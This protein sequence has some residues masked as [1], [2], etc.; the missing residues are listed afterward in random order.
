MQAFRLA[1]AAGDKALCGRI[2]AGM[3][4]QANFLGH[5]QRAADLARAAYKGANGYATP[6]AMALFH[7]MEAR[8]LASMGKDADTS[9]ALLTAERW[10]AQ[11]D[12]GNDPEWIHYFDEAELHAEFAHSFRDLGK[13]DLAHYHAEASVREAGDVYVRSVSFVNTVLATA[14][15]QNGD[16]EQAL[17]IAKSVVETA[18]QLKS[19]RV[20]SY[21]DEFRARLASY[22]KEPLV[23]EF[24]DFVALHLPSEGTP[25]TRSLIVA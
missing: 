22:S 10:H 11:R 5:Y 4:H 17:G 16:L 6:T 13:A 8:A 24:F 23:R 9:A 12:V 18:G 1:K 25:V 7:A 21:L 14:H 19:F 3:S 2:L 15:L 20:V